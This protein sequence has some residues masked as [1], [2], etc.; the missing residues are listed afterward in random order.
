L[1]IIP[2]GGHGMCTTR[3]DEINQVLLAFIKG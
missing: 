1:K 2:G 3:A